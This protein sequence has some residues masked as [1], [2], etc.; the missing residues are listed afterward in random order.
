VEGCNSPADVDSGEHQSYRTEQGFA[1]LWYREV[2]TKQPTRL[3]V[4]EEEERQ[5]I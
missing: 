5:K 2:P 3:V 1:E 4:V